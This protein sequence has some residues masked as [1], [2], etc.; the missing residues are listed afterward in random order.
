LWLYFVRQSVYAGPV[1]TSFLSAFV[2]RAWGARRVFSIPFGRTLGT[3]QTV[4]CCRYRSV[5]LTAGL[6]LSRS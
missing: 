2:F 3:T 5:K 4:L 1:V 6:Y